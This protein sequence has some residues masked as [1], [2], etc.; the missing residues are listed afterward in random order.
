MRPTTPTFGEI[1]KRAYVLLTTL[2]VSVAS[3]TAVR[4]VVAP[5]V[6]TGAL[7]GFETENLA[8]GIATNAKGLPGAAAGTFLGG[9]TFLA[10]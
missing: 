10:F 4:L 9:V 3:A 7:S 5:F 6:L 2:L 8:A 1:M